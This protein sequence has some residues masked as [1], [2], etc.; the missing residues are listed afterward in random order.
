MFRSLSL[1][2]VLKQRFNKLTNGKSQTTFINGHIGYVTVKKIANCKN[3]N[4]VNP[5]YFMINEMIG[6]FEEKVKISI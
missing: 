6:Y 1:V 4:S 3:I 5:L 2:P